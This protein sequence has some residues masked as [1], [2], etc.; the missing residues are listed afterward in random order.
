MFLSFFPDHRSQCEHVAWH[1]TFMRKASHFHD[2]CIADVLSSKCFRKVCA[3]HPH[4]NGAVINSHCAKSGVA[5]LRQS[6]RVAE[7]KNNESESPNSECPAVE[8][9]RSGDSAL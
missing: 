3:P 1:I 2:T 6:S 4:G 7:L 8:P 5:E 9:S